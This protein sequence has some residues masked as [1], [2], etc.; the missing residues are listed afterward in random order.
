MKIL[1]SFSRGIGHYCIMYIVS[2]TMYT[3]VSGDVFVANGIAGKQSCDGTLNGILHTF[4]SSQGW[5]G[6][7]TLRTHSTGL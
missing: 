6:N 7:T 5:I 3:F 4:K 2:T 1:L